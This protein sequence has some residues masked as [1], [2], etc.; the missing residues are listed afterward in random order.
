MTKLKP[1]LVCIAAL[2]FALSP[3]FVTGFNGFDPNAFPVP[4]IDPPITPAGYA[5]AIWGLIY[6]W[7]LIH[8]AYG[9]LKRAENPGWDKTRLPLILSLAIGAT[10]LAVAAAAPVWATVLIWGMLISALMAVF[11]VKTKA[12]RWL[13]QAPLAIYAG[14]L[15][16]ASFVALGW[17]IGG[18]GYTDTSRGAALIALPLAMLFA[19]RVQWLLVRA[20]EYGVTVIW[21]LIGVIVANITG[22]ILIPFLALIGILL[23][24]LLIIR[25]LP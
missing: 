11:A 19:L 12:D 13:L 23:M 14:W 5:F 24:A 15:S 3:Y 17:V 7:L 6:V 16:V 8:A 20:P 10:W 9:L 22:G 25:T 4:Q 2:A 18:Y 1:A 21:A